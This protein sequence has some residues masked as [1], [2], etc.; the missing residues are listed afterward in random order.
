MLV[1]PTKTIKSTRVCYLPKFAIKRLKKIKSLKGPICIEPD[2]D[3]RIKDY[4]DF[5]LKN[6][7]PYTSFTNLRH[8]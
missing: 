1:L 7:L 2:P 5:C 8:S 6:N 4:K 3:K